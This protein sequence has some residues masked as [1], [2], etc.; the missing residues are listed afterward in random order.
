[1]SASSLPRWR[2]EDGAAPRCSHEACSPNSAWCCKDGADN[3][4][5]PRR[6]ERPGQCPH[7]VLTNRGL[8]VVVLVSK[9]ML[10]ARSVGLW[11]PS[12]CLR[13]AHQ[14]ELRLP[15]SISWSRLECVRHS[16]T[17]FKQR[18][19][20]PRSWERIELLVTKLKDIRMFYIFILGTLYVC[21]PLSMSLSPFRQ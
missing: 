4:N 11:T 2:C 17:P 7:V 8:S 16:S 15:V 12:N 1:L 6:V 20:D 9:R 3:R 18:P 14:K 5:T 13:Y 21:Q 10:K 19:F